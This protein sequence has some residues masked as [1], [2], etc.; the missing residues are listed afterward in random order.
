[1]APG[2]PCFVLLC[3]AILCLGQEHRPAD[4]VANYTRGVACFR[5][6]RLEEAR[7]ALAKTVL[8]APDWADAWKALG[9]DLLRMTAYS[10][11]LDPLH[12]ACALAPAEDDACYLEGRT[13]FL[14]ARYDEAAAPLEKARRNAAAEDQARAERSVALN[15]DKLG[16]ANEAERHFLASLRLY[17][18]DA[19]GH[20][21]PRLDYGVFLL[22]QG[23]AGEAIEPLKQALHANPGSLTASVELGRAML[24]LELPEKALPYLEKAVAMDPKAWS[25]RMLLGKT[26]LRLGR[27]AEGERELRI[28]G[29]DGAKANYGSSKVQ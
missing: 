24:D 13:L 15:F 16:N 29:D 14:L 28:A 20:E 25:V 10:A 12:R 1:M 18:P 21:D 8:S 7:D 6:G 19:S 22:R 26:Y 3:A 9:L 5:E 23:R 4:A 27:S 2:R 17:L 11:A